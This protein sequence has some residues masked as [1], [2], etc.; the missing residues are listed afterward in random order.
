MTKS[1]DS[2]CQFWSFCSR[3]KKGT[4][5]HHLYH[6]MSIYT[7][8]RVTELMLASKLTPVGKGQSQRNPTC[9]HPTRNQP[10]S[11]TEPLPHVCQKTGSVVT[12][13]GANENC[14]LEISFKYKQYTKL[15]SKQ[16]RLAWRCNI[17][18]Y[19]QFGQ[20]TCSKPKKKKFKNYDTPVR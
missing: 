1:V 6:F 5:E 14:S 8:T 12:V 7:I 13:K 9:D 18:Q 3:N 17:G 2:F 11:S 4:S 10:T 19:H 16:K 20:V 15:S